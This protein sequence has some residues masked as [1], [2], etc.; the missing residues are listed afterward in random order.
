MY[1]SLSF[2][3]CLL[4]TVIV[5]KRCHSWRVFQS[6]VFSILFSTIIYAVFFHVRKTVFGS[7][8]SLLCSSY[9]I[10]KIFIRSRAAAIT[11]PS[12]NILDLARYDLLGYLCS[13]LDT[14]DVLNF[15]LVNHSMRHFVK[16]QKECWKA[17]AI[18][19]GYQIS[20]FNMTSVCAIHRFQ[21]KTYWIPVSNLIEDFRLF[22]DQDL[23]ITKTTIQGGIIIGVRFDGIAIRLPT[24]SVFGFTKTHKKLRAPMES[25][26]V[27]GQYFCPWTHIVSW[28]YKL[29]HNNYFLCIKYT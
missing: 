10:K 4:L 7:M 23:E 26:Q 18:R 17:I 25:L 13:F 1:S 29:M 3:C 12:F 28:R 2:L 16:H 24:K 15:S 19:K 22:H 27:K 8:A 6:F 14:K 21:A 11:N 9:G 20:V 5:S